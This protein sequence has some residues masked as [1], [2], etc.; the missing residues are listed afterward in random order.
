[1]SEL[2]FKSSLS[3]DEIESNFENMDVFSCL[4]DDLEEALAYSKGKAAAE[5][6]V[7]KRSLPNVNVAEVRESLSMT[8]KAF[9]AM[10]G[11]SCRTVEAWESG[12]S[13]P[14]P[15]AKKLMFLIQEDHSLVDKL[16]YAHA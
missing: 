12:K 4:M 13:T 1:M 2:K 6:F 5:T 10:L 14:T 11:V 8:Q 7:R 15:T 3:M 9:A 16:R